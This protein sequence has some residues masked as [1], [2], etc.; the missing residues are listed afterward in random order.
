MKLS[1]LSNFA[2]AFL[3]ISSDNVKQLDPGSLLTSNS[4]NCSNTLSKFEKRGTDFPESISHLDTIKL[5]QP[6]ASWLFNTVAYLSSAYPDRYYNSDHGEEAALWLLHQINSIITSNK[7]DYDGSIRSHVSAS[8]ELIQHTW[9]Q[10]SIIARITPVHNSVSINKSKTKKKKKKNS[11]I[12]ISSH[13]DSKSLI[14]PGIFPSPGADDNASGCATILEAFR[15]LLGHFTA[16]PKQLINEIQFHWYS[17]EEVGLKG[18]R[19]V[20][21]NTTLVPKSRVRAQLHQDMT[22]F[23][24]RNSNT[25]YF[26]LIRDNTNSSL[27]KFVMA[28]VRAL[29][30]NN[31]RKDDKIKT[32][33]IEINDRCGYGCSDHFA[34]HEAGIPV[35]Y[36]FEAPLHLANPFTHTPLDTVDRLDAKKMADH[37]QVVVGFA[38][39]LGQHRF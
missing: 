15:L 21:S 34:A 22:G 13:L 24:P 10:P 32:L 12:I 31:D 17:G 8:A 36:L 26:S 11:I 29:F 6:N 3:S 9:K 2:V 19:A 16:H 39:E 28:L 23:V 4:F 30:S 7:I 1:F 33:K 27:N 18:S 5:L 38:I 14:F 25:R 35:S 20:L 37:A